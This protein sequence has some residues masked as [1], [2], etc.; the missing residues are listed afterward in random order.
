ME[1][2]VE[3]VKQYLEL[4]SRFWHLTDGEFEWD[5]MIVHFRKLDDIILLFVEGVV[6]E[7]TCQGN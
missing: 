6:Y 4:D 2:L 3:H 1:L 5:G 7:A